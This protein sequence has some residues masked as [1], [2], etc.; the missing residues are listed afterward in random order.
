MKQT[1]LLH[2]NKK[3]H[4]THMKSTIHNYKKQVT[5]HKTTLKHK[6]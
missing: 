1:T 4:K 5:T 6:Q 3:Q 2:N